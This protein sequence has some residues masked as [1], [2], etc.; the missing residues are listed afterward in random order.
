MDYARLL[1]AKAMVERSSCEVCGNYMQIEHNFITIIHGSVG[2]AD[3]FRMYHTPG[4]GWN[5]PFRFR[6]IP[7]TPKG[8]YSTRTM[9][10][11]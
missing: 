3:N 4:I 5:W 1:Q 9:R 8:D 10:S 7:T 6:T 2:D 11:T